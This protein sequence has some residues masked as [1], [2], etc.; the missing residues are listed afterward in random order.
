MTPIV[1]PM[2]IYVSMWPALSYTVKRR[3]EIFSPMTAVCSCDER[4]DRLT[5][6]KGGSKERFDVLRLR[7]CDLL[8]DRLDKGMESVALGNEVG[9]ELTSTSTPVLPS[10]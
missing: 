5:R 6:R 9:F 8:C 10:M 3:T 7:R 4:F 2:W 1:P